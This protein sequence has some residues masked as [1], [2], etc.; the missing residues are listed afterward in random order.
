ML[1]VIW[2]FSE[3]SSFV[4]RIFIRS[5]K[6]NELDPYTVKMYNEMKIAQK[7]SEAFNKKVGFVSSYQ[8]MNDDMGVDDDYGD[9]GLFNELNN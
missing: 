4:M 3:L 5:P 2:V 1:T 6:F 8:N 7:E 9:L